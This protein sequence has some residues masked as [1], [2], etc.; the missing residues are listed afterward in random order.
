[1]R[2]RARYIGGKGKGRDTTGTGH[3]GVLSSNL[4]INSQQDDH[5]EEADSPEL[6]AGEQGHCLR[7]HYEDQARTF[8]STTMKK[9]QNICTQMQSD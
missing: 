3:P 5:G 6:R 9:L 1:M 2:E 8:S 7:V 4:T